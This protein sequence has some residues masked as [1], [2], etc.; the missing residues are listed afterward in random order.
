[1][2]LAPFSVFTPKLFFLFMASFLSAR[3]ALLLSASMP[4]TVRHRNRQSW[5]SRVKLVG[6][7][8]ADDLFE[9]PGGLSPS[10][11]FVKRFGSVLPYDC[12][13]RR[14]VFVKLRHVFTLLF[15][16]ALQVHEVSGIP[17]QMS[18][19]DLVATRKQILVAG[20]TV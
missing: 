20:I 5:Y 18:P 2:V 16:Q 7:A 9:Q 12:V 14:E 8:Q 6:L 17:V 3:S 11:D 19:A 1:M 15:V 13:D 4:G 10:S